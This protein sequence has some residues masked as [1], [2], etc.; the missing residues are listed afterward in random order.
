MGLRHNGGHDGRGV[1]HESHL[2]VNGPIATF[3]WSLACTP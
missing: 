3:E 1:G 2:T